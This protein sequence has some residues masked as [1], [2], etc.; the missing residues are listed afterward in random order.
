MGRGYTR[1]RYL[2]L[3]DKLKRAIPDAAFTTDIIVG[4]PNETDE[5]FEDTM[6]LVRECRFDGAYTF[7]Y[8]PRAGTP[9]ARMKDSVPMEVKKERLQ[10]LNKLVDRLAEESNA[11]YQDQLVE[12]LV[13]GRSRKNA[14]VLTGHT[15]TNK[16]VNF[17]GPETLIGQLVNVRIT[18][19]KMWS[20]DGEWQREAEVAG[21]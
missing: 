10:R 7:I 16:V 18:K 12:V 14:A 17:I 21:R 15:R 6:S 5:Q 2:D 1:E 3:F 13:E 4:F 19:A 9:A 20:L 8:S 11:K